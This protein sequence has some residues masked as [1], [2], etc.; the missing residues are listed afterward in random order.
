MLLGFHF[1]VAKPTDVAARCCGVDV[2]SA[3]SEECSALVRLRAS[4]FRSVGSVIGKV[5][6]PAWSAMSGAEPPPHS[7]V[8]QIDA[9][10][11]TTP[12]TTDGAEMQQR[13]PLRFYSSTSRRPRLRKSRLAR[14]R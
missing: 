5:P 11:V 6:C 14:R 8:T 10:A 12:G 3:R 7:P 9:E 1:G 2:G 4:V 13:V